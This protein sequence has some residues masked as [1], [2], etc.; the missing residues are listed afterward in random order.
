MQYTAE[1]QAIFAAFAGRRSVVIQA[2]AG[3]GKTTTT[4]E[5]LSH[6]PELRGGRVLA[7]AFNTSAAHDL[8]RKVPRGVQAKTLHSLGYSMLRAGGLRCQPD[9]KLTMREA[10]ATVQAMGCPRAIER[11][12]A[13][14]VA[15]GVSAAKNR[16]ARREALVDLLVH[17]GAEVTA[18]MTDS[19]WG[20]P[21]LAL[22]VADCLDT[23]Y[24][25][26]ERGAG[27]TFDDMVWGPLVLDIARPLADLVL[28]D[29]AQDLNRSRFE[30]AARAAGGRVAVVG[31]RNQRIY[32]WNGALPDAL[33]L[34]AERFDAVTL[35]LTM[36]W[37]CGAS[38]VEVARSVVPEYRA[39]PGAPAGHVVRGD[40]GQAQAGDM[41]LGRTN[42]SVF[43]AALSLLRRGRRTAVV[44]KDIAA[45]LVALITGAQTNCGGSTDAVRVVGM[46]V[47]QAQAEAAR[48]RTDG[49]ERY[50]DELSDMAATVAVIGEGLAHVP[51]VVARIDQ[52]VGAVA[53]P[54]AVRCMT[55]HRSKGAEADGVVLLADSLRGDEQGTEE[56]CVTYVGLS[57]A[58]HRLVVSGKAPPA[59]EAAVEVQASRRAA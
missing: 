47:Q 21:R 49:L 24:R 25:R 13:R 20:V 29:E 34:A 14:V 17:T 23:A 35:P 30:L 43:S 8:T 59:V 41:V 26:L 58:R 5:A 36:T 19:G 48:A 40:V 37:R 27:L 46:A 39:R 4:A 50:A 38:I 3:T 44:G 1:Q 16:L 31:D 15:D 53:D 55:V 7:L 52:L 32:G 54:E 12:V 6:A 56:G 10:V 9:G 33:G 28:I 57:R 42:A 2:L 22:A 18:A 11:S 45:R 51:D